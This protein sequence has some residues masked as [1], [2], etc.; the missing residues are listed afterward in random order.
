MTTRLVGLYQAGQGLRK[1]A[2]KMLSAYAISHPS[3]QWN[4]QYDETETLCLAAAYQE[5]GPLSTYQHIRVLVDGTIYQPN[6]QAGT[7]MNEMIA[8]QYLKYGFKRMLEGLNGDFALAL[9]DGKSKELWLARDRFGVKP[10]YYAHLPNNGLA[11]ASQPLALLFAPGVPRDPDRGFVARFAGLHYRHIDN[12]LEDSP[13]RAIRQLTPASYLRFCN[14]KLTMD[15]YWK[16]SSQEDLKFS[17]AQLSEQYRDLFLDAVKIR[18]Q[19]ATKPA[20]TLSGGMDSSSVLASAVKL[21]GRKQDAFSSV[22]P[23]DDFDETTEISSMLED[24][25]EKWHSVQVVDPDLMRIASQMVLCQNEPV[26]TATWLSHYLLCA[27]VRQAGFQSLFGGLGG[28]ELNAGEYE[29]YFY[30]FSDLY[31]AKQMDR[32]EKEVELWIRYHDHPIYRKNMNV[33]KDALTSR[34]DLDRPGFCRPYQ[35]RL[36]RYIDAIDPQYYD[37]NDFEAV[38]DHVFSSYLKN[39]TY[40]DLT[41]ETIPLCLRAE[42][43]QTATFGLAHFLPFLDYRLVEFLYRVP[44]DLKIRDGITKYLLR[45]AMRGVLPEDTRNRVKKMGWNAPAHIWFAKSFREPLLDLVRS[46]SFRSRGIFRQDKVEKIVEA[47]CQ[48]VQ[49]QRNEENHM[50]FLWQLLNLELWFRQFVDS[51]PSGANHEPV[52]ISAVTK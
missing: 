36:C 34:V 41:R 21:I 45:S 2:A 33:V 28:D 26:A 25:V 6:A 49:E 43:R 27:E 24:Y 32:F 10:L 9:Y 39:R 1:C 46:G 22:Y 12:H 18:L 48:I 37:L 8:E 5:E 30:F 14:G 31:R 35:P 7:S 4:Y 52:M 19:N 15:S 42:D 47:H 38:T 50:M 44:G 17:E 23:H 51:V 20:F 16:L 13:F 29:Y 11:F 3:L 40:Q